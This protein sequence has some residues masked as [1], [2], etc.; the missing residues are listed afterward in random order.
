MDQDHPLARLETPLRITHNVRPYQNREIA[1]MLIKPN[2]V[3]AIHYTLT[4]DE[5]T[6]LDSSAEQ[7]PLTFL[8]GA[9]NI[10]PGLEQALTDKKAG[11]KI[12]ARI[13][14]QD[15]YGEIIEEMVQKV[16]RDAF[17]EDT[18]IEIGMRFNAQ[19]ERG[20]LTVVVTNIDD[21]Q[22][23]VDGNHP[24]AGE[25]LN[26]DVSV[27]EVRDATEEELQHGHVHGPGGHHH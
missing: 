17:A 23:T 7:Q 24:L 26:F 18:V 12:T 9:G 16:P 13:E 22:V 3:V 4:D 6:V 20:P 10:I 2:A 14:P 15:G 1:T 27:E 8:Y 25:T 11:D 5:G 21:E 19:T